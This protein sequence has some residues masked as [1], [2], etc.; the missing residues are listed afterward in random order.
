MSLSPQEKLRRFQELLSEKE[1]KQEQL[2]SESKK[3][4]DELREAKRELERELAALREDE[5]VQEL[6]ARARSD[7]MNSLSAEAIREL[8]RRGVQ[9]QKL[10][11]P[12]EETPVRRQRKEESLDDLVGGPDKPA[13]PNAVIYDMKALMDRGQNPVY[14]M[15]TGDLYQGLK[16]IDETL[17]SGERLT[18]NQY[19]IV[20]EAVQGMEGPREQYQGQSQLYESTNRVVDSIK[21]QM[22]LRIG[23][24]Y[25]RDDGPGY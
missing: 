24:Q 13:D 5:E 2:E 25:I 15:G 1:K 18:E 22:G 10:E 7:V 14:G 4:G 23:G 8:T 21:Q 9:V 16:S 11:E 6:L 17:R 20:K 12:E 19:N 3:V